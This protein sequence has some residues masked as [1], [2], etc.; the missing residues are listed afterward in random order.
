VESPG[1]IAELGA[2]AASD[3]LRPK[4]LAVL[5][6]FYDSD[7]SFISEGPVQKVKKENPQLVHYYE[8][9]P[10]QLSLPATKKEFSEMASELTKFL[11]S[12]GKTR[13]KE[14]V[15]DK[16]NRGHAILMVADLIGIAGVATNTSITTCL[17][18]IG[19]AIDQPQLHRYLSLLESMSFIKR[20]LRSNQAFYV[21]TRWRRF[22]RYAYQPSAL[23]KDQKRIQAAIRGALD[24]L[25]K[26]ILAKALGK[27]SKE[28]YAP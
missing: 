22:I 9:D 13:T 8:W 11:E 5:N 27:G 10:G 12:R 2:F 16:G 6:T 25:Q 19:C 28:S 17:K 20:V 14:K 21:S 23:L 4:T 24:P 26:R 15:F 7:R 3:V 18:E 1:S